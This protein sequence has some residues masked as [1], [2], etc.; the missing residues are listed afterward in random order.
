MFK[1]GD[2]VYLLGIPS[3]VVDAEPT[4]EL[5][6][7]FTLQFDYTVRFTGDDGVEYERYALESEL[8]PRDD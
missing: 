1:V 4:W 7:G 8:E 3:V 5:Q 6:D 2:R